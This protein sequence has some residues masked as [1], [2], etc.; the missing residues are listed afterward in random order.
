MRDLL[1]ET[2]YLGNRSLFR[3]LLHS[4]KLQIPS[5]S[6]RNLVFGVAL[7]VLLLTV[8][9]LQ[10]ASVLVPNHI[11]GIDRIP[12]YESVETELTEQKETSSDDPEVAVQP[13]IVEELVK[14]DRTPTA[15]DNVDFGWLYV[16][17]SSQS[18]STPSVAYINWSSEH[19]IVYIGMVGYPRQCSC[20]KTAISLRNM[21]LFLNAILCVLWSWYISQPR[22]MLDFLLFCTKLT[23]K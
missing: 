15:C 7:L 23:W 12:D 2:G 10:Q 19:L 5:M 11:D 14:E 17:L 6:R 16:W 22:T 4:L 21:S 8:L 18:W 20:A 13:P 9:H 1:S 3:L